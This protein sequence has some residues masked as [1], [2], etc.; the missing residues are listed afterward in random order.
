MKIIQTGEAPADIG[1]YSQVEV[2]V[3]KAAGSDLSKVV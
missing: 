1:P 3:L 2:A